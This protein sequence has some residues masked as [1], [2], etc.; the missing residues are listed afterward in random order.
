MNSFIIA[1]RECLESALIVGIIYTLLVKKG[2]FP[3]LKFL[4]YGVIAA[5]V[6][7]VLVAIG[8]D[9]VTSM[10]QNE[11]YIKLSEGIFMLITAGFLLYVVFWLSKNVSS[12]EGLEQKT[13]SASK[14]AYGLGI[15]TLVFFAV[16]REGF[17]TAMFLFANIKMGDF[18]MLGFSIGIILAVL[19]GYLIVIRGKKVDLRPFFSTSTL[20][21]VLFA[22][23]MVAYG[24]HE[25]EE[26]F[27][28][29]D[30][31]DKLGLNDKS[32]I[33]RVWDIY[34]PIKELPEGS[35][36]IFYSFNESKGKYVHILHDK[37]SIGQFL[38]GFFGYNSDPNWPEFGLW[39]L[40]L[41]AGL[42]MWRNFYIK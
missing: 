39:L 30:H 8:L 23:G 41:G 9:K 4:W 5:I 34:R 6:A 31:L 35:N 42:H 28:K 3:Q 17:E 27:V 20:F 11:S 10:I 26:F 7:S 36:E 14:S 22:A 38:K 33:S 1:F 24:S 12:K 15:F 32:E 2:L 19:I 21:L 25:I 37:G 18:S 13:E 29:G 16:L 40:T